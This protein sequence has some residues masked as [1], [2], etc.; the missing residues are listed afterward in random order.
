LIEAV[1]QRQRR[2]ELSRRL[3][4]WIEQTGDTQTVFGE[5]EF[6][7]A[8]NDGNYFVNPIGE[9]A[10]PWVVRDPNA[11]RYLWCMSDGNRAIAVHTSTS[12]TSMG[13]KHIVWRAPRRGPTSREIWAPEL[14]FL[15]GRW[16]IYFAASDGRNENH[17]AYVLESK[18]DDPLGQYELRGPFATGEGENGVSPNIWAIDMTV[19]EH[20]GKRY[21]IWSGW[22]QPGSD[23]QYLYIAPMA[24]PTELSGP[25]VRLCDND[26]YLWERVE[27]NETQRGL[28]EGPQVFQVNGQTAIVYSCGASWL[29]TYKLG[30]LELTGA[31]PL[32]P[33]SWKKRAKPVFQG[34]EATY[35]VGHSC[36]VKSLDDRQWWHVFHAK[37][38]R[39]PGWRR[40]VF[41]QPMR[42]GRRGFPQFGSPVAPGSRLQRPSGDTDEGEPFS[43]NAFEY[44]GHHQFLVVDGPTI[45]L[46]KVPADPIN[47]YRSGEKVVFK[48]MVPDDLRAEVTIDFQGESQARD[49]GLLLRTT[50]ASVGYDAQ[51]GY[52]VGLIPRT[53]LVVLGRTDGAHWQELARAETTI[54]S[55][56]P[57]RL[58]VEIQDDRV[59]VW[60]NDVSCIRHTDGTYDSGSVGLRVV[61]TD[62]LFRDFA[63]SALD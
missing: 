1:E 61:D 56:K 6:V 60:H 3:D 26:D 2:T 11:K 7:D 43:V 16:Y 10:D 21:A 31:E 8:A 39:D 25:R 45:R 13:T 54:D 36:F 35:G 32:L 49:A 33:S 51:R 58:A 29:P 34:T 5:P 17:L 62:A 50:A 63:I 59:H 23:Q 53:Q 44:F 42:V 22:D 57:Q 52:F 15:D 47:D 46:G 41:V 20:E 18:T 12:I 27:P 38:D 19:L 55:T 30:L 28:N 9:G 4:D 24:S 48:G 40:A 14:H 37:R